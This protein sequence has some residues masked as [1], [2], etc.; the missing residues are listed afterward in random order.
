MAHRHTGGQFEGQRVAFACLMFPAYVASVCCFHHNSCVRSRTG[1]IQ[2]ALTETYTAHLRSL[3]GSSTSSRGI[4]GAPPE[5]DVAALRGAVK[6]LRD[7]DRAPQD[8]PKA[9]CTL[10]GCK[11]HP[12]AWPFQPRLVV[13][14]TMSRLDERA[15]VTDAVTSRDAHRL[16]CACR[17]ATRRFAHGTC[18]AAGGRRHVLGNGATIISRGYW[19]ARGAGRRCQ[20]GS[21]RHAEGCVESVDSRLPAPIVRTLLTGPHPFGTW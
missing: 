8:A 13:K 1:G 4:A 17:M 11:L 3:G 7:A 10:F 12:S 5:S 20:V 15:M 2:E 19:S 16:L 21:A 14:G 18:I 6:R 9:R